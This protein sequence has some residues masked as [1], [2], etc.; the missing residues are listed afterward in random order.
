MTRVPFSTYRLQLHKGFTFDDAA[1]IAEYLSALGISHAYCSPYLQ[2]APGSM[3]GYDVVDHRHVNEELGG[4]AGHTRL[5]KALGDNGLGQVLDIVPNHMS[6]GQENHLWWDVIENGSTSRYASFFDIDWNPQEERLRD[7]VLVPILGDQYGVVLSAGEIRVTRRGNCFFVECAG[8][9]LPV[10]PN[11]LPAF[12]TKAA[13]YAKS[14][15]LNF[16]SASYGRLPVPAFADR[17]RILDRN[18]DKVVLNDLL[19]RL[20]A[21]QPGVCEGIDRSMNELN[22]NL[23]GLDDF[24]NQQ[25][26]R[27]AYWKTAD[28]QLGYRR[29]FDVNT[30]IGLRVELDYVFDETHELLVKWLRQGVLDGIRVDHPDGLRDPLE[31]FKRLRNAAPN[32]WI[33]GEKILEP[34]EFLRENWPIQGTSGYDFLNVAAGV[35]LDPVGMAKLND[36][37]ARFTGEP[38]D[39]PTIAH[40]KKIAVTQEAL[41]S[42]VNRLTSLFVDVCEQN[43]DHRDSTRTEI[44]RALREVASCFSVYRTYVV[45]ERGEM[46]DE[47]CEV[48]ELA[49]KC[50]KDNKP[51]IGG[52]LFDF[53][54]DVLTLKVTGKLESEFVLRF[55][56]FTSPVMAKGVEDTA[57]YCYNRLTGMCEVGG[58][59]GRNG[60]SVAEFHAYS[61]KMQATHPATMVT[62]STHDTKRADD[63]R[64]RLA[65]LS[66]IPEEFG[67]TVERWTIA[68]DKYK[69]N[70]LPDRNSEYFF[71]QTLIG[72][73][74]LSLERAKQYMQ[75]AMREAKQKTSWVANNQEF[76]DALNKFMESVLDDMVFMRAMESFV[77]GINRAGRMN[78]LTQTLLKYTSPGVPDLYQGSEIWDHSLVDPDNRRPVDYDLRRKLLKEIPLLTPREIMDRMEDGLPK[79]ALIRGALHLRREKPEWFGPEAEYVALTA[80][81]PKAD[82]AIAYRRGGRVVTVAPRLTV[83][84]G[85]WD[86]T[87]V[88]LPKGDWRNRVTGEILAGGEVPIEQL[89]HQFPVALLTLEGLD[90]AGGQ[91]QKKH[92]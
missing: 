57:F 2:A 41:G 66:E 67:A 69:T 31:Y 89:L 55:Q 45:P 6:L 71:Y 52:G 20:C 54:G 32:A 51:E 88:T 33:I 80:T 5:C 53:I 82:H 25:N 44:R 39:F 15:E 7:K 72:A 56:Q 42:D 17:R 22:Q 77:T 47:D 63:V 58:D 85:N 12:L 29:F 60:Y 70:G 92:A 24:L 8:Q 49:V 50:A 74:P 48:V 78:S 10:A 18:R 1:A 11:S 81:G 68:N 46:T 75:K 90:V 65:V 16:I 40:D 38:T 86:G 13:E 34:G 26:Y 9:R 61:E 73:W 84:L 35:L 91:E 4:A 59:P 62:L 19:K 30:L 79:M 28:Q 27:L 64:A 76:E 21:E 23:D 43:R 87:T 36:I 14:D 3:H 37:Y 83:S